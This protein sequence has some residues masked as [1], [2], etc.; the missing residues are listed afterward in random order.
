MTGATLVFLA[1]SRFWLASAAT[2]VCAAADVASRSIKP[3]EP[4][5]P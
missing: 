4:R 5:I 3:S 1:D 2:S